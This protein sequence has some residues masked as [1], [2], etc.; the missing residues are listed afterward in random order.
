MQNGSIKPVYPGAPL[1]AISQGAAS[2]DVENG[3]HLGH[4][5][6]LFCEHD[7]GA[8]YDHSLCFGLLCCILPVS[9][10][11]SQVVSAAGTALIESL[12]L[13][14]AVVACTLT[15]KGQCTWV[16]KVECT[17]VDKV[18]R[19]LVDKTDC[20]R[21]GKVVCT[22]VDKEGGIWVDTGECTSKDK[23]GGIWADT[24]ECTW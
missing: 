22:V 10:H 2:K 9:A 20:I 23:G 24:G 17:L 8:H 18:E 21:V 11:F 16:D 5:A 15:N 13:T 14:V 4:C 12:A 1:L 6:A 7:A 19:S 3:Q